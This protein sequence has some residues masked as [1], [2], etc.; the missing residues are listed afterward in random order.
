[1]DLDE[2]GVKVTGAGDLISDA[3]AG[4]ID[5]MSVLGRG[6]VHVTGT[7]P[8]NQLFKRFAVRG[9]QG[10]QT[11]E[12]EGKMTGVDVGSFEIGPTR[13]D[14]SARREGDSI[15]V[16][17]PQFS[18]ASIALDRFLFTSTEGD[19][20]VQM[21]SE[22]TSGIEGISFNGSVRLDSRV[23]GSNDL[24]DFR[25]AKVH[26]ESARIDRVYGDGLGFALLGEKTQVSIKSGAIKGIHAE[27]FDVTWPADPKAA[28]KFTG[29]A[30]IDS[31]DK[32]VLGESFASGWTLGGGRIDATALS[33][34]FLEDGG[35]KASIGSLS[36]SSFAVRGPD[37]WVRFTL[38]D[39]GGKFTYRDGTLDI[40]DFHFGSLTVAAIHWKVG[41]KG[42]V[43]A[44]EPSTLTG[45]KL[46]GRIETEL[47][48]APAKD[49]KGGKTPESKRAI[50][51]LH[52]ERLHIDKIESKHLIYQDEN[53]RIELRPADPL[54]EKHMVGF[55]PLFL[56]NLDVW[57]L[58]WTPKEGVTKGKVDLGTYEGSAHYTGLKSGLTAGIAL[59]GAGMS[60]EMV[61]PDAF[62]VDLGKIEKTGGEFH[63]SKFDTG[64]STGNIVGKVA[65]G[66]DYVE[67]QGVE[68]DKT[69]L[70]NMRYTDLPKK[71]T[72]DAVNIDRIKLGK[73][74][75]NY[76]ISTD[77]ATKGEKTPTT[78]KV[79]DLELFDVMALR[80]D[81]QGESRG[82]VGKGAD[83]KEEV[84]TQHIKGKSATISHLEG[85][86]V[87][88]ERAHWRHHAGRPRG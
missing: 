88:P 58:D 80:F 47:Q 36:L 40:E 15:F 84:S 50:K 87:R 32:L 72:L 7:G 59:R 27:K 26:V 42:F 64:F 78:L 76:N 73:V 53:N 74:R 43:E 68:I 51:R 21:W 66:P 33:A 38:A 16:E 22:G 56:Q 11:P 52:I 86:H 6:G 37:G 67:L 18:I 41:E 14:V 25:L 77:P 24:A 71:L 12:G 82:M 81:Y 8:D 34:E 17:V 54:M 9:A 10:S 79:T 5:P 45:L 31:I 75:Q 44:K 49:A 65:M 69:H 35:V 20:G 1:M 63:N 13:L 4:G 19:R 2:F 30:G 3:L 83:A 57:G 70:S 46:K 61:G 60:A 55:K 23:K 28:P 85:R 29:K 62:T 48:P 39:L